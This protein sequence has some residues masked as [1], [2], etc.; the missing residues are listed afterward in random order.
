MPKR[1]PRVSQMAA[2]KKILNHE[3]HGRQ[4]KLSCYRASDE[5]HQSTYVLCRDICHAKST[6]SSKPS[7]FSTHRNA[8]DFWNSS[9]DLIARPTRCPRR[10]LNQ[11][12]YRIFAHRP[13][14]CANNGKPSYGLS[15]VLGFLC[16]EPLIESAVSSPCVEYRVV[17]TAPAETVIGCQIVSFRPLL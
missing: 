1:G 16:R 15:G 3:R 6:V 14:W 2:D 4:R 10:R 8:A 11:C 13:V 7:Q 17:S 12:F 9:T 5:N